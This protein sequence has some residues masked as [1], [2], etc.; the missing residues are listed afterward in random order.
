MNCLNVKLNNGNGFSFFLN[1]SSRLPTRDAWRMRKLEDID[2]ESGRGFVFRARRWDKIDENRR[3]LNVFW[4]ILRSLELAN[5]IMENLLL[6]SL[7]KIYFVSDIYSNL[8]LEIFKFRSFRRVT[9]IWNFS[10]I[11]FFLY[12]QNKAC[13]PS[14]NFVIRDERKNKTGKKRIEN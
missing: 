8:W 11:S 12:F 2:L 6:Q 3:F 10:T 1:F 5:E 13:V 7:A 9:V 14:L 4:L